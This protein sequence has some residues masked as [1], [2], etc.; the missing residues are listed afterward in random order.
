MTK[1]DDFTED[2]ETEQ[3]EVQQATYAPARE[4]ALPPDSNVQDGQTASLTNRIDNIS[5]LTDMQ[6]YLLKLF[7]NLNNQAY[8][9][10]MVSR[11]SPDTFMPMM[12]ILVDNEV[13]TSDPSKE[14]NVGAIAMR[15]YG[16]LSI[17]LDGKG[18]IDIA[19]LAGVEHENKKMESALRG[20][21]A[22]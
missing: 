5:D 21:G 2:I 3:P 15:V 6:A 11:I 13:M 10:I 20:L 17:G 8:D 1:K 18:R 4:V 22:G 7:P 16:L 12:R 14:I 19:E 9:L